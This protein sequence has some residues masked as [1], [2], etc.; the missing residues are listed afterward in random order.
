[1][2]LF[3]LIF[4]ILILELS[5]AMKNVISLLT[6]GIFF[7]ATKNNVISLLTLG[8]FFYA[9]KNIVD[10]LL[11]LGIFSMQLTTFFSKLST[12]ILQPKL[13][14]KWWGNIFVLTKLIFRTCCKMNLS[15]T[16][17][18]TLQQHIFVNKTNLLYISKII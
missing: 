1:M 14:K 16:I 7:Y 12:T 5:Y 6:L 10:S 11:N 3:L 9:T 17:F 8:I 2:L 15:E 13:Y 4:S 18:F